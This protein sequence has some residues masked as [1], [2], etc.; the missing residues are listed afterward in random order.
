MYCFCGNKK[1]VD[2][3]DTIGIKEL[4]TK[5]SFYIRKIEK[6]GNE[7]LIKKHNKVVAKIVPCSPKSE[8]EKAQNELKG[9]VTFYKDPTKPV[10]E[11]DW[12]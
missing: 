2:K 3:M 6:D 11:D 5:L 10:A 12:D 4:K 9:S 8:W 7:L 1:K